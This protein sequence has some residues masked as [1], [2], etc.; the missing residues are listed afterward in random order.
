M[1]RRG[2]GYDKKAADGAAAHQEGDDSEVEMGDEECKQC[3]EFG[4]WQ[5][6]CPYSRT[7]G[8]AAQGGNAVPG[9]SSSFNP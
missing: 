1:V 2:V 3:K 4:H 9:D 5:K 8:Q 6:E 7:N